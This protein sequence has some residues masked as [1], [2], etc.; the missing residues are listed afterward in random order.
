MEQWLLFIAQASALCGH[1][2]A[3][4]LGARAGSVGAGNRRMVF[5]HLFPVPLVR[6]ESTFRALPRERARVGGSSVALRICTRKWDV[7]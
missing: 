7:G 2:R 4:R 6:C 1:Y 5:R 3:A